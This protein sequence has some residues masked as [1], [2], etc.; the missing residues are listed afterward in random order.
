MYFL[1]MELYE[2]VNYTIKLGGKNMRAL[3][4]KY[5]Q[6]LLNFN[7]PII[8][9]LIDD[10]NKC[11]NASL[12]ID[13]IQDKSEKRRGQPCAYK[14]FGTAMT[15]NSGYLQVFNVLNNVKNKYPKKFVVPF[16]HNLTE[17]LNDIHYGQGYDIYWSK[18]YIIPSVDD[19]LNMIDKKTGIFFKLIGNMCLIVSE[20][21]YTEDF[22]NTLLLLLQLMGRFFQIRDDY[23]NLTEPNYWRSKTFCQDFD[24]KKVSYVFV[25]LKNSTN[26]TDLY[27]ELIKRDKLS[28]IDKLYFYKKI[29]DNN[30]LHDIY[31]EL[32]T[33]KN[34][35]IQLEKKITNND[36]ITPFLKMFFN[37]L[38]YNA[39]I[40]YEKV[41][42]FI[43]IL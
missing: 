38:I 2:P 27:A 19:F 24:E 9:L 41:K 11:H 31:L 10:L 29:Y 17:G 42:L 30:I 36:E 8:N 3:T 4:C 20:K 22:K 5:V 40:E 23:I 35:I 28:N 26:N 25:K 13:D 18:N 14:I 43:N 39:P 6:S 21:N 32:D 15:I 33:Y 12:I 16:L 7:N 34:K 37:K 1:Y